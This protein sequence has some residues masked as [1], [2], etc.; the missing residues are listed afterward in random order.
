MNNRFDEMVLDAVADIEEVDETKTRAQLPKREQRQTQ[1]TWS[2]L[3][4]TRTRNVRRQ[5]SRN[6]NGENPME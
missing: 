1:G 2:R 4:V 5:A 6:L 3:V